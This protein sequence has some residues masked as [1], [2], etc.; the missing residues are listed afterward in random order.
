MDKRELQLKIG[1]WICL[2][3]KGISILAVM[4][5]LWEVVFGMPLTDG[6]I[7]RLGVT[8]LIVFICWSISDFIVKKVIK[9]IYW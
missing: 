5:G 1:V 8:P 9:N 6:E 3:L 2:V 7:Y 4:L